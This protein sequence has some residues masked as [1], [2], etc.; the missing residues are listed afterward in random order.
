MLGSL[1]IVRE[2]GRGGFARVYLA[3]DT[4]LGRQVALKVFSRAG[5]ADRA[6]V[7][8]DA[9]LEEAR[10]IARLESAHIVTLFQLREGPDAALML[11]MEYVRG[12]TLDDLLRAGG[13]SLDQAEAVIRGMLRGLGTAHAGG[14]LHRDIK[15][16]NILITE[17][18]AAKL[19]DFGLAQAIGEE[20]DF[21]GAMHGT[22][23]YMAPELLVGESP[24]AQSDLW[25]V[26][27]VAYQ[28]LS[29]NRPFPASDPA[30]FFAAVHNEDPA[31]LPP[32]V[33]PHLQSLV[34]RCLE[35]QPGARPSSVRDALDL[36]EDK[37]SRVVQPAPRATPTT[38]F[39]GRETEL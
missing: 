32:L 16:A 25:S 9:F 11:E 12:G 23:V 33:P 7:D 27:V 19:S 17:A 28:M 21:D 30:T 3:E 26:G 6:L 29:G 37:T 22:P 15:P 10:V 13:L 38:N 18:G 36:L 2:L 5:L 34:A 39:H 20:V 35:K 8:V 1:R 4:R 24:S 31:P 14:V